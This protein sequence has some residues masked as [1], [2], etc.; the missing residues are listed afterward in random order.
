M[1]ITLLATKLYIPPARPEAVP[2]PHLIERLDAGRQ[3]KLILISA[4]AGFGKTTLLSA[5]RRQNAAPAAWLSLDAG[6]NDRVRFLAYVVA[7]LQTVEPGIGEAAL[8]MLQAPQPP[9]VDVILTRFINEIARLPGHFALILD[10]YHVIEAQPIHD[11]ITFLLDH[12]PPQMHLVIATRAD[13]PLPIARLRGRDQLVELRAADLRFSV[14]EAGEFLSRVTG[15]TLAPDDIAALAARTEGWIAGLQMAAVS[16]QGR[17]IPGF[18]AAFAG[19]HEYI[20]DYLTDEVLNR[21]SEDLK[22]FLLQTCILD[23]LTAPLCDAVTGQG[24][25]QQTLEHL[26][27]ANLF[28]VPLDDRREWYRYHRL[29]ADLLRQRLQQTQPDRVPALHRRASLW[30]EQ[31]GYTAEAIDHALDGADSER[32]ARLVEQAAERTLMRSEYATFMKWI[33]ALPE[34]MVRTRPLLCAYHAG[35]LLLSG[36][37][38]DA[39]EARLRDAAAG[40]SS[41]LVAGALVVFDAM[42]A[43]FHGDISGFIALS[44]RALEL[45]PEDNLVFRSAVTRNLGAAYTMTSDVETA[46]RLFDEVVRIGRQTGNLASTVITLNR[47]AALYKIKGQLHKTREINEQALALAVDKQGRRLPIASLALV[48]LGDVMR[49]WNDLETAARF[50]LEGIELAGQWAEIWNLGSY[51]ILARIRQAQGDAEGAGAAIQRARQLAR[52]FDA[53]ELDDVWVD[54]YHAR[55]QLTQGNLEAAEQ[56]VARAAQASQSKPDFDFYILQEFEQTTQARLRIAQARYGEALALIEPLL[57]AA[58]RLKRAGIAL[59]LWALKALARHGQ[60]DTG[61]ALAALGR[62]LALGEPEGYARV[63][64]DEGEPMASLLYEA[65]AHGVAP[66]YAG[67][68]LAAFA[69][70]AP[71]PAHPHAPDSGEMIEPLSERE[72]EVLRLL[73]EGF[74]N[75][76]IAEKL[77]LSPNTVKRHNGSIYG[78]LGVGSRTQAIARAKALGILPPV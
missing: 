53:S 9:P 37:P 44:H 52:E 42:R 39:V 19:S 2:R 50:A 30:Y 29:F 58:E 66:E 14:E 57:Q 73:A 7:A 20:V 6:D 61:G 22:A 1:S 36:R 45:L 63:F 8:S 48:S 60:G 59:E 64:I 54:M 17:D 55:L 10:D 65:A 74:S 67:R 76:E 56:W 3:R 71:L 21:Q 18:V 13:P 34:V 27:N 41:G 5:W 15:S 47:L 77:F 51:I 23:R 35:A 49:E 28:I 43:I 4:P 33:E 70:S 31:H 72:L 68:L 62:A 75:R 32:A 26:Q 38:V 69:G 40:D 24:G 78:K 12:Q 16:M 46:I 25:G 11:A